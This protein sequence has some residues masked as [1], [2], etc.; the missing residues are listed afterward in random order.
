MPA[1]RLLRWKF[2]K[3]VHKNEVGYEM[4]ADVLYST[5]DVIALYRS[6]GRVA[7]SLKIF[8]FLGTLFKVRVMK[9][10]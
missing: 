5:Q 2:R 8:L 3:H 1:S 7:D 9:N 4:F 10:K 6:V